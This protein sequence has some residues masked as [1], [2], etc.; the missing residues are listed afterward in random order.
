MKENSEN[1]D[2][3]NQPVNHSGDLPVSSP[4]SP[5]WPKWILT[6][7]VLLLV[8]NLG[9]SIGRNSARFACHWLTAYQQ[10]FAGSPNV[11]TDKWQTQG[12]MSINSHGTFGRIIQINPDKSFVLQSGDNL[13]LIIVTDENTTF[14]KMGRPLTWTDLHI[15]D[16]AVIIGTATP[17]GQIKAIF[18]RI[19]PQ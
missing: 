16:P 2:N 4:P 18:V 5:R 15:N 13:E 14:V 7:L 17:T 10:N 6:G 3:I 12:P 19:L 11:S 9:V 8:F 1:L